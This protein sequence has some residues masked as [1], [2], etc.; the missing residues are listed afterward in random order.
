MSRLGSLDSDHGFG[1]E[2][3]YGPNENRF[4]EGYAEA[5][6]QPYESPS[7]TEPELTTLP[8][9]MRCTDG[10]DDA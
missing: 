1:A 7:P 8:L 9:E 5:K 10:G 6:R 3:P 4:T 2:I